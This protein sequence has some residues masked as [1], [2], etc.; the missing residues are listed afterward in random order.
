MMMILCEAMPPDENTKIRTSCSPQLRLASTVL[1]SFW[2]EQCLL[3]ILHS[4]VM[5]CESYGPVS[6]HAW[7]KRS[8]ARAKTPKHHTLS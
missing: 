6:V 3:Q 7:K 5:S 1:N 4:C 2:S 8:R